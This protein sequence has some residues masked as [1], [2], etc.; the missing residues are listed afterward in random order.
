MIIIGHKDIEFN[1][2]THIK[3]QSDL[4]NSAPNSTIYFDYDIALCKYASN[5][6]IKFAVKVSSEKEVIFASN[7]AASYIVCDGDLAL[8]AQKFADEYMIDSK[9]LKIIKDEDE[10]VDT[11]KEGIDGVWLT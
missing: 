10:I 4:K 2:I 6:N 5:N 7:F 11:A 9:I 1:P 3:N 8:N